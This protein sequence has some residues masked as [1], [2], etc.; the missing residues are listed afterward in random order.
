MVVRRGRP[1]TSPAGVGQK[2]ACIHT[3]PLT[4][5]VV[6]AH[7]WRAPCCKDLG[8]C[9]GGCQAEHVCWVPELADARAMAAVPEDN[10]PR[11][12]P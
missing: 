2:G 4:D 1:G 6:H 3:F 7:V 10:G 5:L 11:T 9:G 8:P 12:V